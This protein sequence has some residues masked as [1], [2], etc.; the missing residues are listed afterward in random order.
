MALA[1]RSDFIV[2]ALPLTNATRG[3]LD[4]DFFAAV[5]R[6]AYFIN[7]GRGATV[8]TDALVDALRSKRLAGA[9]LDVTDPEPL[10][11]GHPL[12][13]LDN[14]L[15]TPH[16]STSGGDGT[17]HRLLLLENLA[18]YLAGDAPLNAVDPQKGY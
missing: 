5:P 9:G 18:R 7:V 6:G 15:I 1:S 14:V 4:A 16:I 12:W 8:D 17:R 3:L 10:P 11:S 13:K 2:N